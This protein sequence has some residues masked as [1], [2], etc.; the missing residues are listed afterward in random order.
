MSLRATFIDNVCDPAKPGG[1]GHSDIVW[2]VS[3]HFL[4]AGHEVTIVADYTS[5]CYPYEHERLTVA[6]FKPR[7]FDRRN[8]LGKIIH[9]YRAYRRALTLVKTDLFFTTDAFSAGIVATLSRRVPTVFLTPANIL[10]RQASSYKLDAVAAAFYRLVSHFAAKRSRHII[11]TSH[12]LKKWWLKT[13][14]KAEQLSVIPLGIDTEVFATPSRRPAQGKLRLLYVA[15]FEGG[16]NPRLL[17]EVASELKRLDIPFEL[18][19]VGTGTLFQT[20]RDAATKAG[21]Q[22]VLFF[23]GYA[24]YEALP[25]VYA[26]HDVFIFMREAGGPPR[27][28]IQ[29]MTSGMAVVA[30][31]AA[32]LRDYLEPEESGFLVKSVSEMSHIIARLDRDRA[33]LGCVQAAAQERAAAVLDWRAVTA[34]YLR[35]LPT[36]LEPQVPQPQRVPRKVEQ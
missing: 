13:G 27:V 6:T 19:A 22:D 12:D 24:N 9:I 17:V 25:E 2:E 30:F 15:R 3:R 18:H 20:V 33:L 14:A 26:A 21:L 7:A 16:N 31:D 10:Q 32:G 28:V 4:E 1:S 23:H 11:A 34:R 5:K 35:L 8:G 29:A 36:L